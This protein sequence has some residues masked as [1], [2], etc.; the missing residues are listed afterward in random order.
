MR[1]VPE[2]SRVKRPEP[3]A[4][5]GTGHRRRGIPGPRPSR[6]GPRLGPLQ[7][8]PSLRRRSPPPG[9]LAPRPRSL[10]VR[11][12]TTG[13]SSSALPLRTIPPRRAPA[14]RPSTRGRGVRQR[15]LRAE[16]PA[17]AL[18]QAEEALVWQPLG[19]A[20]IGAGQTFGTPRV[21]VSGRVSTVVLDPGYDGTT[22]QTVYLGAAQGGVW[23]SRNNGAT[24]TPLTDDQPSLAMG[25]IAIDPEPKRNLRGHRRGAPEHGQLLWR[26]AAQINRRRRELAADRRVSTTEPRIPFLHRRFVHDP[27]D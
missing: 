12:A 14:R 20:P 7:R 8:T 11:G 13:S 10:R 1:G 15:R 22:N 27:G 5:E 24:W 19:P 4:R 17:A 23:R 21:P 9:R 18:A 3:A 16:S 26:G 6:A 25:A 2:V